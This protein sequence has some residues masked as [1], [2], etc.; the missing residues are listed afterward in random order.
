MSQSLVPRQFTDLEPFA[1]G[2]SLVE[3]RARNQKRP[4]ST[5]KELQTFDDAIFPRM[6][7]SLESLQQF[8]L[9]A[10]PKEVRRLFF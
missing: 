6:E 10:M 9:E 3:E 1:A 7:A 8:S 5:M 2:R 4:S